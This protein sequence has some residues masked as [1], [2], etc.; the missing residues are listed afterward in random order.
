[1]AAA[2]RGRS[3]RQGDELVVH[4]GRIT[5]HVNVQEEPAGSRVTVTRRGRGPLEET[6]RWVFGLGL[7]GFLLA[8]GLSW[9]NSRVT[10]FL[11]PLVTI[12]LFFLGIFA[13]VVGLYVIDRSL[14]RRSASLCRSLEDAMQG[15]PILVLQR[16]VDGLERNTAI[17]NGV[18]FY[19]AG[20]L[21]QF[22]V[23]LIVFSGGVRDRIDEAAALD[24]MKGVFGIPLVPA[25]LFGVIWFAVANRH[26]ARR[27][28]LVERR[29]DGLR[30]THA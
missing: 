25:I 6:R 26:H 2:L 15:D 17:A 14:E 5:T 21:V 23:Y 27:L 16:E 28:L 9:Y 19:C 20:L 11:S 7:A 18:L 1:M 22:I 12:T 4:Y 10:E 29:F 24:A 13:T 8:W 3:V 30:K